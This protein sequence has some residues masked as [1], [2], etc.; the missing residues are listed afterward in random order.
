MII[1]R[2]PFRISLFGGG[3][4]YPEWYKKNLGSVINATINK[5]CYISLRSYPPFFNF[6]YYIRYGKTELA[7]CAMR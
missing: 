5:Y 6:K 4:D 7:K 3:T 2:T 1:S